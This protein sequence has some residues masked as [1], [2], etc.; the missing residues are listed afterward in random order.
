MTIDN[1]IAQL[2]EARAKEPVDW[3]AIR[4]VA[5]NLGSRAT[6]PDQRAA[7]ESLKR[8]ST[9]E[10]VNRAIAQIERAF[11]SGKPSADGWSHR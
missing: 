6:T 7:V 3:N 2:I 4:G 9:R 11:L 5:L 1:R 10:Q 8:A